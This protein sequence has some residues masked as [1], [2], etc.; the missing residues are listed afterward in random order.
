MG[1][2]LATNEATCGTSCIVARSPD[3]TLCSKEKNSKT[4]FTI[5]EVSDRDDRPCRVVGQVGYDWL[6]KLDAS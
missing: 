5:R 1:L 4:H 2:Q 6:P 3:L